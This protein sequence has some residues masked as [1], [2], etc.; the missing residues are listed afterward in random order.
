MNVKELVQRA[1]VASPKL[2]SLP[3][4]QAIV[5]VREIFRELSRELEATTKGAIKVAGFGTF[6]VQE[7]ERTKDGQTVRSKRTIFRA[8]KADQDE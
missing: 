1:K 7:V 5:L 3:D 2:Q 8:P 4:D 6:R